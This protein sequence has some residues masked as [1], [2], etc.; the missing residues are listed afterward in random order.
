M[1]YLS[2]HS[3]ILKE[4]CKSELGFIFYSGDIRQILEHMTKACTSSK[5][6]EFNYSLSFWSMFFGQIDY[7]E[8]GQ[9]Q[10]L[11]I[12]LK[13][14]EPI[15]SVFKDLLKVFFVNFQKTFE[16]SFRP[17]GNIEWREA[18]TSVFTVSI[19]N[20]ISHAVPNFAQNVDGKN[21][22]A[23][24]KKE[25]EFYQDSNPHRSMGDPNW[26]S[27]H[28]LLF[29]ACP[30]WILKC[31]MEDFWITHR[32][33]DPRITEVEYLFWI[34]SISEYAQFGESLLRLIAA[35]MDGKELPRCIDGP[36]FDYSHLS[37]PT[38]PV[39]ENDISEYLKYFGQ[40]RERKISDYEQKVPQ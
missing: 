32:K 30:S 11:S 20:T 24:L 29:P 14:S 10:R 5:S 35:L 36:S 8:P 21:A 12:D 23:Y 15:F 39:P 40:D 37:R 34:F 6:E 28:S 4:S 26:A 17:V 27:Y 9:F 7:A 16:V 13:S 3:E 19:S 31:F 18:Y 25:N 2:N 38:E 22:H 33:S 1:K